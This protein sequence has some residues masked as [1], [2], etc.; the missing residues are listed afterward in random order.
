MTEFLSAFFDTFSTNP[1][2]ITIT[3][4]VVVL[5]LFDGIIRF[6]FGTVNKFTGGR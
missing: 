4:A 1:D 6:L 5:I 2:I 3:Q